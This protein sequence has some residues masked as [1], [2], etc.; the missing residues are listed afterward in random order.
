MIKEASNKQIVKS[1]KKVVKVEKFFYPKY[2]KTLTVKEFNALEKKAKKA[3][4]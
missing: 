1:E 3:D 2:G 4:K